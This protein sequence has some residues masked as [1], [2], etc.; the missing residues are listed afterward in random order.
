MT[1]SIEVCICIF[2]VSVAILCFGI[3]LCIFQRWYF[4]EEKREKEAELNEFYEKIAYVARR[5][6]D[7]EERYKKH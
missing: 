3:A 4:G 7:E 5:L 6:G 2:L 1:T